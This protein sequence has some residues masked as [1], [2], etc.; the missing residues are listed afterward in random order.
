VTGLAQALE[1]PDTRTEAAEAIRGLVDA[2]MLVPTEASS[3][4]N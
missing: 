2:I 1:D 3:E 4:S